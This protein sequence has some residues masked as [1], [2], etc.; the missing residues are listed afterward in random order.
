M[1]WILQSFPAICS[2]VLLSSCY[3]F[4]LMPNLKFSHSFISCSNPHGHGEQ[5]IPIPQQDIIEACYDISSKHCFSRLISFFHSF[6]CR[7]PL[8][9]P[10]IY[11]SCSSDL[12]QLFHIFI[13]T[14]FL[15]ARACYVVQLPTN[16]RIS[17]ADSGI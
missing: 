9:S 8:F 1:T 14:Q 16:S 13:K 2:D 15:K 12:L 3:N 4:F 7:S 11:L 5:S 10:L 6:P 17:T